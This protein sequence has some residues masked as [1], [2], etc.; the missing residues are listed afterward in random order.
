MLE[1]Y[2]YLV[3]NALV[4]KGNHLEISVIQEAFIIFTIRQIKELEVTNQY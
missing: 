2:L 1:Q 4:Y 3:T